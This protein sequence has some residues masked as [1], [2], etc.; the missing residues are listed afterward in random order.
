MTLSQRQRFVRN[1]CL[2]FFIGLLLAWPWDFTESLSTYPRVMAMVKEILPRLG[3]ALM[4]APIVIW[5]IETAAARELLDSFVKDLSP[6]IIGYLL[7]IELRDHIKGYLS[8]S[9]V[10]TAWFV[11]YRLIDWPKDPRYVEL[12]TLSEY[13]IANRGSRA[14]AYPFKY[15]LENS[16]FPA[17]GVAEILTI[18]ATGDDKNLISLDQD[19][20]QAQL[21]N[22]TMD[23]VK[24]TRSDSHLTV[25]TSVEIPREPHGTYKFTVESV[26]CLPDGFATHF[27]ASVPTLE[28][29]LRIYYP[30]SDFDVSLELTFS[31][32]APKPTKLHDGLEWV[33]KR[34]MLPG[35]AII[36]R[37]ARKMPVV[38]T[39]PGNVPATL[40]SLTPEAAAAIASGLSVSAGA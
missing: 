6:H 8:E 30:V 21:K 29:T 3:D 13:T 35:Q 18:K 39:P 1:M 22:P 12:K 17:V 15:E 27:I 5:A 7:P 26:E 16:W 2:T 36:T 24:V 37:W 33:V 20:L 10:R 11:E 31:E 14:A 9:F 34:P 4:I 32:V 23:L 19:D 40:T 25:N 38:A 28:T